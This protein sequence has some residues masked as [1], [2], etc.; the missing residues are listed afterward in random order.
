M[1]CLHDNSILSG[2][3]LTE[4]LQL[5]V[6]QLAVVLCPLELEELTRIWNALQT[7]YRLSVG[8]EVRIALL[9]SQIERETARVETKIDV[10]HQ[11]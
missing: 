8:Y 3:Q 1:Q 9:E 2:S 4:A 6:Q 5:V 7:P 11:V 10:Y